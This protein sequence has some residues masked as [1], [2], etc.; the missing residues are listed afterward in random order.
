M[1]ELCMVVELCAGAEYYDGDLN[2]AALCGRAIPGGAAYYGK[3]FKLELFMV[4]QHFMLVQHI[5][6]R[7]LW[8]SSSW[9]CSILW[10]R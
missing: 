9:W 6:W 10:G 2:V 7:S 5:C 3:V 4:V 8:W 1:V